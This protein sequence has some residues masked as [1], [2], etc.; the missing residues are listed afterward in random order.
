MKGLVK[1]GLVLAGYVAAVLLAGAA[2][3]VRL[4]NTQG[5]EADA[6][7]GMYAFGD[8]CLFLG[9]LGFAAIFP[10]GLA[11]FFLRRNRWLWIALAITALAIAVTGP[12]ATACYIL[13]ARTQLPPQSPLILWG[14]VAVL[15]MLAAPLLAMGFALAGL[16]APNRASRWALFGAAA[17]EGAVAMYTVLHWFI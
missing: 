1:V 2:L 11:L 13:A 15:R 8:G 3:E 12:A 9:V 5:P 16:I 14:P 7:A 17:V 6:S 10:T 4:L